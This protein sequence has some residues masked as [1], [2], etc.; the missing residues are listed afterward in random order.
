M[1]VSYVE[2][3]IIVHSDRLISGSMII[4]NKTN[5]TIWSSK[6]SDKEY[7]N[8]KV[9]PSW[10]KRVMVTIFTD[11]AEIKKAITL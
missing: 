1:L 10:P 8:V 9:K 5:Q 2:P 11:G 7:I 6:F 4:Q 3:Y